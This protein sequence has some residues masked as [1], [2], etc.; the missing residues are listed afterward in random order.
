M[1]K[2]LVAFLCLLVF[3]VIPLDVMATGARVLFLHHSTGANVYNEGNV[4]HWLHTYDPDIEITERAYPTNGYPWA[5][6]PY[7]YWNLWINGKCQ[8]GNPNMECLGNMAAAY[9]VIIFK[10]CFPGAAILPDTG[11]PDVTSSRKSL[12]NYKAQYRAL[13]G[14]MD[15]YPGTKFIIWTL[16]PLHRLATNPDQAA[17]AHQFVEWVKRD[18]LTEDGKSHPNI[19]IFDFFGIVAEKR[20]APPEGQQYCLCYEYERSHT[21][22][23]SHPNTLANET[24]GPI[25]ARFIADVVHGTAPAGTMARAFGTVSGDE[26]YNPAEDQQGDGDVDGK[27]LL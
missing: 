14:E 22:T 19:F 25:F 26:N 12:E 3:A 1:K 17:R 2:Q 9:D 5:N 15:R 20:P 23:D 10:H 11:T 6:Y 7:D 13:R 27:D 16:V 21:G 8:P 24:A 4:P 18:F